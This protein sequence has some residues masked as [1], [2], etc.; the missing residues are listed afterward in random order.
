MGDHSLSKRIIG[1]TGEQGRTERGEE[2]K[3][4][5]RLRGITGNWST[6]AID[7]EI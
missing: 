7:T 3:E 4:M 6:T 2:G 1:R 5:N